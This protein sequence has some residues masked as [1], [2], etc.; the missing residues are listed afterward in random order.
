MKMEI[1]RYAPEL[2]RAFLKCHGRHSHGMAAP[3][4]TSR[5]QFLDLMRWRPVK[6][7]IYANVTVT[8]PAP[9]ASLSCYHKGY[10]ESRRDGLAFRE[11][12][13]KRHHGGPLL[14]GRTLP[15]PVISIRFR[16]VG[17]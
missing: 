14:D 12:L 1:H 11:E 4:C 3:G 9:F 6:S 13:K 7:G 10:V 8:Y 15:D 2:N 17:A 5:G 16:V